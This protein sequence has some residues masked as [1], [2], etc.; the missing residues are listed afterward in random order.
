[1]N[2]PNPYD[3]IEGNGGHGIFI[4]GSNRSVSPYSTNGCVALDNADLA[5]LDGRIDVKETPVII[6]ETLPYRFNRPGS[7]MAPLLPVIQQAMRP[8]KIAREGATVEELTVLA[9][10]GDRVAMGRLRG[11][12]PAS[13]AGRSRLYMSR[14]SPEL[15][16]LIKREWLAEAPSGQA[17]KPAGGTARL[18]PTAE[19]VKGTV[20]S[21]RRA[22]ESKAI[23]DYISHYHE[24][25][26]SKGRTREAW[27]AYKGRLN[28][29]YRRISVDVSQIKISVK[30]DT[31]TAAFR[32]RYRSDSFKSNGYKKLELKR[33][34]GQW[35]IH[36]E[37]SYAN[38]PKGW[39]S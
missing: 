39:P 33:E 29:K 9:Y 22:W 21:W 36:R 8:A 27:K 23:D 6:G 37:V 34:Q 16:V 10:G 1:L 38:K 24:D 32:Q 26:S 12:D 19:A 30:G 13:R 3:A 31:A 18:S 4:H 2:Y 11:K 35:K 7:D 25:F 28:K 5:D 14:L 20:E 17:P 15:T